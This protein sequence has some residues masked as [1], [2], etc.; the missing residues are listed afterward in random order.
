MKLL[1]E[2]TVLA[3]NADSVQGLSSYQLTPFDGYHRH[4]CSLGS[5]KFKATYNKVRTLEK[6]ITSGL[7]TLLEELPFWFTVTDSHSLP[8]DAPLDIIALEQL[9]E[10]WEKARYSMRAALATMKTEPAP[11]LLYRSAPLTSA[12]TS[13]LKRFLMNFVCFS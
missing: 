9:H 11:Q 1:S 13:V 5:R 6:K 3:E 2:T 12:R 8:N 7:N 4:K 10:L